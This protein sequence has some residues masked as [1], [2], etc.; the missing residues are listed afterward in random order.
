MDRGSVRLQLCLI[1]AATLSACG[2]GSGS[3]S[4]GGNND[5]QLSPSTPVISVSAN[6]VVPGTTITLGA[7]STDPLNDTLT[8]NWEFGDGAT[9]AGA[10]TTH[11]YETEGDFT[12]KV[13][14]T[15]QHSKWSAATSVVNVAYL[16]MPAPQ[17]YNDNRRHLLGETFTAEVYLVEPNGLGW[18]TSWDYGDGTSNPQ[19]SHSIRHRYSAPGNYIV[20]VVVN[21]GSKRTV[22][23]KFNVQVSAPEPVPVLLDNQFT[24]YC[25]G[26]YC[27]AVDANTY[28]GDGVGIW[29]YHN[30]RAATASLDVSIVGVSAGQLATLVFSNGQTIAAGDLPGAG[31]QMS[32]SQ[33]VPA[34]LAKFGTAERAAAPESH[35]AILQRNREIGRKILESRSSVKPLIHTERALAGSVPRSAPP[36]VGTTRQ[37]TDS[38]SAPVTYNMQV[39]ATCALPDGRSAVFWLDSAQIDSGTVKIGSATI[40]ASQ[41]CGDQGIYAKETAMLG[42]A[43][44]DAANAYPGL[45]HDSPGV[46]QDVNIVFPGVPSNTSWAGYFDAGSYQPKSDNPNSNEAITIFVS[47]YF[48]GFV[49]SGGDVHN[50]LETLIHEL[51]HLIN[52][53]QRTL[54]RGKIHAAFLEETSAM[55]SQ[56]YIPLALPLYEFTI[57][58][59]VANY[60][61]SGGGIGYLAWND[62]GAIFPAMYP[63]GAS[64]GAFLHRRYGLAVDRELIN[65]CD[66]DGTPVSS[67][68]CVD[69]IIRAHGGA[70]FEDEFARVG[71]T[72]FGMMPFGGVPIG[73]GYPPVDLEGYALPYADPSWV[74]SE[75]AQSPARQLKNGFLATSHTFQRDTVAA[76]QI[77][78]Q[79]TG[80]Q[81]PAGT[82]VMLVIQNPAPLPL[83][84]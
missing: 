55:M 19:A 25:S 8:Y 51:A 10:T 72:V 26:P 47:G 80:I 1:A 30:A 2:G 75:I 54:V 78:Y 5:P 63:Q 18:Y 70:G 50:Q 36:A 4:A 32:A 41:F 34:M 60:G 23:T 16:P 35:A 22:S 21:N 71:A 58:D 57:H 66:D 52:F 69:A 64:F 33:A 43:Y 62:P 12:V 49:G 79:R 29:R 56:D 76:G 74:Q 15:D 27:G 42:A 44:G 40:M 67:Y 83:Y 31:T 59:Y 6:P 38:F 20:S 81:V 7:V 39:A 24:P 45:I 53:Y 82:T 84:Y 3:P 73:F 77:R 17:I 68:Q 11:A 65:N 28:S 46:L 13:T 9:A 48:L 37:W 14:A 61:L